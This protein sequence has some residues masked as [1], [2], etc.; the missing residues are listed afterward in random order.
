M[1]KGTRV[2]VNGRIGRIEALVAFFGNGYE[3]ALVRFADGTSEH[4]TVSEAN[5]VR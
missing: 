3:L 5:R 2:T 1:K 4:A